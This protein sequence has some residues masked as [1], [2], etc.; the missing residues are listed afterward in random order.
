MGVRETIAR[1]ATPL[2]YPGERIETAFPAQTLGT[3]AFMLT[4]PLFLFFN[5]YHTVIVTD[6]RIIV[7]R[8]G[9]IVGTKVK[10]HLYDLP[11]N[12]HV[13]EP[14]GLLF[15]RLQNLSVKLHVHRRFFA[16][17]RQ[18]NAGAPFAQPQPAAP[19]QVASSQ[20]AA[21]WA[22]SYQTPAPQPAP[23]YEAPYQVPAERPAPPQFGSHTQPPPPRPGQRY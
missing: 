11:R 1:N 8:S 3:A 23:H 4:Q 10:K 15:H 18:I 9:K 5:T 20:P 6:R 16:D 21:P 12:I 13:G 17:L 19:H 14:S 22:A 2:L 7:A